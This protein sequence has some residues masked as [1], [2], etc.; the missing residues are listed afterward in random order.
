MDPPG[1]TPGVSDHCVL[2]DLDAAAVSAFL[3][4]V[5][6]GTT[7]GLMFAELRHR[8]GA[9]ARPAVDGG[10][11]SHITGGYGLFCVAAAPTPQAAV[12][13]RAAAFTVIRACPPGPAPTWSTPSRRTVSTPD[14]STTEKT[15]PAVPR[16]GRRRTGWVFVANHPL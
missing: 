4:H 12:A 11:L 1:P 3:A 16:T 13:G 10:V 8:G 15:W 6:E 9:I 2:G 5:G 7:S 14:G